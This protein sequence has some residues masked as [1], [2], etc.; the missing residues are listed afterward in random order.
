MKNGPHFVL[1]V[2]GWLCHCSALNLRW[3]KNHNVRPSGDA[4]KREFLWK[5]CWNIQKQTNA[6]N[7]RRSVNIWWP[8]EIFPGHYFYAL[9]CQETF[10]EGMKLK[11]QYDFNERILKQNSKVLESSFLSRHGSSISLSHSFPITWDIH[12]L[13]TT[14]ICASL[15]EV[16]LKV[17]EHFI[18]ILNLLFVDLKKNCSLNWSLF[19][20][21]YYTDFPCAFARKKIIT[22]FLLFKCR[23]YQSSYKTQGI[24]HLVHDFLF[25]MSQCCLPFISLYSLHSITP[26]SSL[27]IRVPLFP[28]S[29]P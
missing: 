3:S 25:F 11:Y 18:Y 10:M 17:C 16:Y 15:L 20:W 7:V 2:V 21:L 13:C 8:S 4:T 22:W 9:G 27:S 12:L 26:F 24:N 28:C 19:H 5:C 29:I 1:H 23:A 14:H 6:Y